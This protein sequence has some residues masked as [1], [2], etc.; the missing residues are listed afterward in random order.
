MHLV[1][2]AS[3]EME[4][5]PNST[6]TKCFLCKKDVWLSRETKDTFGP[7][8]TVHPICLPCY[9][10]LPKPQNITVVPLSEGQLNEVRKFVAEKN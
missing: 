6:L 8:E 3:L 9:Q 5:V 1:L 10:I 2:C 4:H 7:N